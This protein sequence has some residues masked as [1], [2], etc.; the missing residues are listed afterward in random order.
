M[1]SRK[2]FY[3]LFFTAIVLWVCTQ[4]PSQ[5]Q[6]T[7]NTQTSGTAS[8]GSGEQYNFFGTV[9]QENGDPP[10]IG[11]AIEL[12]CQDTITRVADVGPTGQYTFQLGDPDRMKKLQPDASI[13]EDEGPFS[14]QAS[15]NQSSARTQ[16]S[17]AAQATTSSTES[18]LEFSASA[19]LMLC[20]LRAQ[21]PGYSSGVIK[22]QGMVLAQQN[23]LDAITIFPLDTAAPL[24]VPKKAKKLLDEALKA[25]KKEDPKKSEVLFKSAVTE[26]PGYSEAWLQLGMLYQ[27][28]RRDPEARVALEKA[29]AIDKSS[30]AACVQL[31]WVAVR[32]AAEAIKLDPKKAEA[33]WKEVAEVSERSIKLYPA[34]FPEAYYLSALAHL[35][36]KETVL[37]E[38]RARAMQQFDSGHQFPRTSLILAYIMMQYHD[39]AGAANE[40][41]NYLRYAPKAEDADVARQKLQECEKKIAKT[42]SPK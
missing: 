8:P 38:K 29:I 4:Q 10:P 21:A 33:K 40:F 35:N 18:P 7:G 41:R 3:I 42:D 16:S 6:N 36:L 15:A 19:K 26:Y 14:A 23:I 13:G 5:G 32:E 25:Y 28:Q 27:K 39:Y 34:A 11:T 17:S 1:F 30:A 2:D 9:V 31:G 20:S 24:K 12:D 22:L 37:A